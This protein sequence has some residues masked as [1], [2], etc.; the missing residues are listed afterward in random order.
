MLWLIAVPALAAIV[1]PIIAAF[2]PAWRNSLFSLAHL[3]VL[4]LAL[5]MLLKGSTASLTGIAVGSSSIPIDLVRDQTACFAVVLAAFTLLALSWFSQ[6]YARGAR[7]GTYFLSL[8][9]FA[10]AAVNLALLAGDLLA[11][12]AGLLSLSFALMLMIGIDFGKAGGAAA[13][14]AFATLEVPAALACV[15]FWLID[16]RAGTTAL[17]T[18][19]RDFG[20]LGDSDAWVLILPL[21][22][23]LIARAGLTPLQ[24]WVVAS[25][26]AAAAPAAIVIVAVALPTGGLILARLVVGVIPLGQPWLQILLALGAATAIVAGIGALREGTALGWLA[27]LAVGQLG[28]AVVGFTVGTPAG[29]LAG[30]LTLGTSALAL[31]LLGIGAALA[32]RATQ[33]DRVHGLRDALGDPLSRWAFLIG[34]LALAPL[35]PLPGFVARRLLLVSLV[36]VGSAWGA[37]IALAVVVGTLLLA[38]AIWRTALEMVIDVRIDVRPGAREASHIAASRAKMPDRQTRLAL[39]MVAL[40]LLVAGLVPSLALT[41][42]VRAAAPLPS[43]L[44]S[45]IATALVFL[46]V[47]GAAF[48]RELPLPP[49]RVARA[50]KPVA[51][52]GRRWRVERLLDP[53]ILI[54]GTLLA[55]GRLSA[56]ALDQTLGRL[57]R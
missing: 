37:V 47:V 22:V 23:A 46:S 14:R 1:V 40:P 12:Y 50:L 31:T 17:S 57:A 7:F 45:L 49:R 20:L 36:D 3:V 39:A 25:C 10:Q 13:L 19:S 41:D 24:N 4:A 27:Y 48:L 44:A 34:L 32:I 15:G 56:F 55:L 42:A 29:L 5:L 30:W 54:G 43:P 26:R 35:P 28:L 21:V 38:V 9:L 33:H 18:L 52:L 2:R 53:Y 6:D 51:Y 16:A 11:L 8:L